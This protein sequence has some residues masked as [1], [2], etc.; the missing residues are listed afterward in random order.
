MDTLGGIAEGFHTTVEALAAANGI[1][2]PD[3]IFAEQI[4]F[5]PYVHRYTVEEGDTLSRIAEGF[6]TTVEALVAANC[7]VIRDPNVIRV[8]QTLAVT[9]FLV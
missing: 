4:L 1:E 2:D 3:V 7:D 5:V 9:P 8:G 6:G